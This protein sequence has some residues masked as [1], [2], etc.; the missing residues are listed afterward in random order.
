MHKR[1]SIEFVWGLKSSPIIPR[2][3]QTAKGKLINWRE[4]CKRATVVYKCVD[5]L[6]NVQPNNLKVFSQEYNLWVVFRCLW[7]K[8]F[9]GRQE[10][11]F[12]SKFTP[13]SM[14]FHPKTCF[15]KATRIVWT[16]SFCGV[17]QIWLVKNITSFKGNYRT[18]GNI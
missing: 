7:K 8:K 16:K 11:N 9:G 1:N 3:L 13:S 10:E 2:P 17:I 4:F 5:M 12:Q 15:A 6:T 18:G 14:V